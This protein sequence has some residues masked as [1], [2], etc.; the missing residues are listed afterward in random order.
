MSSTVVVSAQEKSAIKAALERARVR[1]PRLQQVSEHVVVC[2]YHTLV[3]FEDHATGIFLRV[4]IVAEP[5]MALPTPHIIRLIANE[6]GIAFPFDGA[7][8]TEGW[9][10]NIRVLVE[11]RG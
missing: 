8:W 3:S 9:T 10:V 5:P 2:G 7:V 11:P 6:Y 1:M 4:S